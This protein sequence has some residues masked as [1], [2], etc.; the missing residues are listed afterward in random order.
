MVTD[1][2]PGS[3][4]LAVNDFQRA[5]QRAAIQEILARFSGKSIDLLSYDDVRHKLRIVETSMRTLDEIPLD[6]I[7][8]SVG[9]YAD[10]TRDFL[11]RSDSDE[12]RWAKVKVA[13]TGPTGLPP[14]EVYQVGEA[15]F[16]LDGNHR[17]SVARELGAKH[18]QAFVRKVRTPVPFTPEDDPDDLIVRAEQALFQEEVKINQ[19]RPEA[20][21]T[22]SVPG[23]YETLKE[24]ISVHR[25]YMGIDQGREISPSEAVAH[26]Y[27]NV[28]QPIVEA[29]RQKGILRDFP[30]RTETDLYLWISDH[31]AALKDSLGWEVDP[32]KAATSFADE[33]SAEPRRKASRLRRR[34]HDALTPDQ[35]ESGPPPGEWRRE[36]LQSRRSDRMFY[37]V[38]ALITGQES[39]WISLEQA[40]EVVKREGGRL[41]G[42]HV[43]PSEED[44]A[45]SELID[46]KNQFQQ[47]C[48][49]AG[50]EGSLAVDVGEVARIVCERGLWNDLVVMNLRYPPPP[51]PLQK[52]SSGFRTLVRRCPR[53]ILAVPQRSSAFQRILL[54]YDGSPKAMEALFV[55]TYLAGCWK[56]SLVVMTADEKGRETARTQG[57]AKAYL[58]ARGIHA[59]YLSSE[60][61]APE[62]ILQTQ[63][64]EGCD[65]IIMGGYGRSPMVEVVLGSSVDQV[66]R[67][68]Q[69]PILLSR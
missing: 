13:T 3:Y 65:A 57:A 32:L 8:G 19:I 4:A 29:I 55:A 60:A 20:Q 64:S 1:A 36:H 44:L 38:L 53:P 37:D 46:L 40:I 9:R 6:S 17:V 14:I 7:V 15:Y 49:G 48:E 28:Y 5:R 23:Q 47:R 18:I 11:P 35:L 67:G 16:V 52:L 51:R 59:A 27:D 31:K 33:Y 66:L 24:H 45:A 42:L 2:P 22:V 68:S 12:S 69:V 10:F 61:R 30:G 34:I 50:V 41:R 43:V 26:W 21:L 58:Q 39:G 56:A 63:E 62:A 25:Y 54:A